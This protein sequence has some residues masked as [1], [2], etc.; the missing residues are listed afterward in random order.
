MQAASPE[1]VPDGLATEATATAR[2]PGRAIASASGATPASAAARART[3]SRNGGSGG[4]GESSRA[5]RAYAKPKERDAPPGHRP[6]HRELAQL[7]AREP[8]AQGLLA[9]GRQEGRLVDEPVRGPAP[10]QVGSRAE[11]EGPLTHPQG[12]TTFLPGRHIAL[13]HQSGYTSRGRFD[14][15][16]AS[17]LHPPEFPARAVPQGTSGLTETRGALRTSPSARGGARSLT[18]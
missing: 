12:V 11:D 7:E 6:A 17:T 3:G 10:A 1:H 16:R 9:G 15:H 5:S 8:L 14:P 2:A 18:A 4:P 13:S